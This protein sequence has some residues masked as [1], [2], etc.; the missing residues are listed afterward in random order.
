MDN[1][2]SK[3]EIIKDIPDSSFLKFQS[4]INPEK[5]F[6]FSNESK[7]FIEKSKSKENSHKINKSN[8]FSI[9]KKI[10]SSKYPNFY[11]IYELIFDRFKEKKCIFNMDKNIIDNAYCLLD[12]Y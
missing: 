7:N 12:I 1:S 11:D 5:I 9:C 4:I 10:F 3:D 6:Q 8:F 2:F